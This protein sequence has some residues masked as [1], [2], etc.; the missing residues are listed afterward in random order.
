[1]TPARGRGR[2]LV[3]LTALLVAWVGARASLWQSPFAEPESTSAIAKMEQRPKLDTNG[4]K[5]RPVVRAVLVHTDLST[6]RTF[7][8]GSGVAALGP[9]EFPIGGGN[10]VS[11]PSRS[12]PSGA[13][14][15]QLSPSRSGSSVS[16][17][18]SLADVA[19]SSLAAPMPIPGPA[20][21][22]SARRWSGDAWL[23]VRGGSVGPLATAQPSYGR[24]QAGGVLRYNLVPRSPLR[25]L[26][27][28]RASAALSGPREQEVAAGVSTR[29]ISALPVRFAAEARAGETGGE[30][31]V[32][33]AAFAVTELPQ[34]PLPMETRLEAYAQ[35]GYVGGKYATAFIDGQARVERLVHRSGGG[36]ELSA[37]AGGW[38]GAQKGASR[39][40]IGPTVAVSFPLSVGRGRLAADYR[41]RVAGDAAPS[42]GP[43]LTLSA[44]F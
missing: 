10:E 3:V 35:A 5:P 30:T 15:Q 2:P 41:F 18:L 22:P 13:L 40:D 20:I 8:L 42:S 14:L 21:E 29:A 28:L 23:L 32:R 19:S 17:A 1:M 26:A 25:P 6:R 12:T 38:G 44:G 16:T 36:V 34:L 37:G 7:S 9:A 11:A 27:Y 31:I 39:L 33:P 24:S 43:A 4:S